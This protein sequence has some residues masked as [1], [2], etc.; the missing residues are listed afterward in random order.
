MMT[1]ADQ[2]HPVLVTG[3]SGFV[4]SWIIV[5]LLK[6]G[7]TVRATL[8]E[9][10]RAESVRSG[11]NREV[12]T[13]KLSF[14]KADMLG[15]D[16]WEDA[17]Q[18]VRHVLHVASPLPVGEFA[19]TDIVSTSQQGVRRIFGAAKNAR[20]KKIVMTSSIE[21]ARP[22]SPDHAIS[23]GIWTELDE[24]TDPYV[25]SKVISER[26]AWKF[27]ARNE[28]GPRLTTIL[29][30][31]VQ[32]PALSEDFSPSI[33]MVKDML[34]GKMPAVPHTGFHTVDVRDLAALH[35]NALFSPI[36]DGQ[37]IIGSGEYLWLIDVARILADAL[38][39]AALKVPTVQLSDDAVRAAAETNS[40]LQRAVPQLGVR[41]ALHSHVAET[42]LGWKVRPASETIADC[43][44]SLL[45]LGLV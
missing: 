8:R 18:D 33:A 42:L 17:M 31:F 23:E 4:A 11:I 38:G 10:A 7:A 3:G 36:T 6:R 26:D 37:R 45:K 41:S 14:V 35:V 34:I 13:G 43:G 1:I 21:A 25:R 30:S 39:P 24:R 27:V 16:G 5:E 32:G 29:P 22:A 40:A 9:L 44:R 2:G 20:V 12:S 19:G 28:D 15:D